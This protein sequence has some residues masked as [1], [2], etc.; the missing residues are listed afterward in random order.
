MTENETGRRMQAIAAGLQAAGLSAHLHDTKGV[1][2]LTATV[3]RPGGKETDVIVDEDGYVEIRYWNHP[4]APPG[5][6][7]AVIIR[8]LAAI[9]AAQ[10][11]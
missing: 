7:T 5:Q 8:A 6:V 10:R 9:A 11:P 2:D 4:G 3:H 1:L